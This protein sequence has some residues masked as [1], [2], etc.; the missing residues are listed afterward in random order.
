MSEFTYHTPDSNSFIYTLRRYLQQTG[1]ENISVLLQNASYELASSG[2]YSGVRWNTYSA[3]IRFFVSVENIHKFTESIKKELLS[4]ADTVFPRDAGYEI[5]EC[6][7][8]SILEPPPD[9]D[10]ILGNTASLT[11]SGI[12]KHDGLMFRSRSETR[13]YDELKKRE[14]LFFSNATAVLG[15]RDVK[16]EPDFLVCLNGKWGILEVMGEQYHPSSTA[17]RDHDRARL[18]KDYGLS[19]IEFY[20]ASRCYNEPVKVVNDFIERL[21]KF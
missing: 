11:S 17:M 10:Q 5:F 1:K 8:S 14:V 4:A 13:I 2:S 19:C 7:I 16:R 9:D 21:A 6:E 3:T 18:F 15:K 20:D 12:I